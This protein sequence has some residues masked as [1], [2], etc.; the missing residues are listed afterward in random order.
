MPTTP[1]GCKSERPSRGVSPGKVEEVDEACRRNEAFS[2]ELL[3]LKERQAGETEEFDEARRRNEAMSE[4]LMS[5]EERCAAENAELDETCRRN[6][7]RC[8]GAQVPRG[9]ESRREGGIG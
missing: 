7:R 4:E 8:R 5:L 9:E 2:E 1:G 3:S 6:E